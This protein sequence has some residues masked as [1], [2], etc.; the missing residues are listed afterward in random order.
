MELWDLHYLDGRDWSGWLKSALPQY[1]VG[2]FSSWIK[3]VGAGG[4]DNPNWYKS[5]VLDNLRIE[6]L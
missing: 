2:W 5:Q 4:F 3:L 6:Q 1:W